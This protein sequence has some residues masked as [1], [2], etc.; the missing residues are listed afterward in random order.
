MNLKQT[1]NW[2]KKHSKK[3]I[4]NELF[5]RIRMFFCKIVFFWFI[6]KWTTIEI[7]SPQETVKIIKSIINKKETGSYI[8]FW[9]WDINIVTKRLIG[10]R[11][12]KYDPKL[13]QELI[14]S[15]Q[16]N[17]QN[18]IKGVMIHSQKYWISNWM[19][20]GF[21]QLS[22][23]VAEEILINTFS[24]FIWEKLYSP[25]AIHYLSIE[26]KKEIIDLFKIIKKI[27]SFTYLIKKPKKSQ[28]KSFEIKLI[29]YEQ[30]PLIIIKIL[31]T[32]NK[33]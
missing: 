17:S 1:I 2:I 28:K 5:Y 31:M 13:Q 11:H 20:P 32:Q 33:K 7:Q 3:I 30:N 25:V 23:V 19:K 6:K 29:S 10:C 4:I 24:Y 22:D 8:R 15:L 26:D 27:A 9:D 16:I 18:T 14:E 12:Q 21:H